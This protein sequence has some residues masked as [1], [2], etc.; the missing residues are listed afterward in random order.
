MPYIR[1]SVLFLIVFST[2][3]TNNPNESY[4]K[5]EG[6]LEKQYPMFVKTALMAIKYFLKKRVKNRFTC[7]HLKCLL[8]DS[9]KLILQNSLNC[10]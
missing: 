4:P 2:A 7:T 1:Y 3:C 6:L 8:L 10:H 5:I 9:Q